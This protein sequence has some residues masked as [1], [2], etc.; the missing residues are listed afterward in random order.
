MR[1]TQTLDKPFGPV[2]AVFLA[3]GIGALVLG[4]L[5]VLAT[6]SASFAK[7]LTYSTQVGPL[8]G[9]TVWA[10]IAFVV[11]GRCSRWCS[12]GV[13]RPPASSTG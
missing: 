9:K 8:S 12:G 10:V 13:T 2:A 1:D 3:A 11:S 7:A 6:A 5:N 4:L